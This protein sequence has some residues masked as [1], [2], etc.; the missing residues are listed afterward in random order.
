MIMSMDRKER[1]SM[2]VETAVL[3]GSPVSPVIFIIYLMGWFSEIEENDEESESEGIS[4]V[5]YVAW[6]IE[7]EGVGE[8]T[9]RLEKCTTGAQ[10]W[11]SENAC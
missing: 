2:D 10:I 11:A 6:V 9:E 5:D 7:A 4:F 1:D 3:Q 8:F